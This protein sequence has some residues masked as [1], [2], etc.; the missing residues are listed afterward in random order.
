V[1]AVLAEERVEP[2]MVIEDLGDAVR[3][4]VDRVPL[5]EEVVRVPE[6]SDLP[7]AGSVAPVAEESGGHPPQRHRGRRAQVLV[8]VATWLLVITALTAIATGVP[9]ALDVFSGPRRER[10]SIAPPAERR[11]GPA[12]RRAGDGNGTSAEPTAEGRRNRCEVPT[13]PDAAER[14]GGGGKGKA[15]RAEGCPPDRGNSTGGKA[16]GGGRPDDPG[17][18]GNGGGPPGGSPGNE[19]GD[20]AAQA[21]G[22]AEGPGGK[23]SS[24]EEHGDAG[25]GGE[26]AER[27]RAG[28]GGSSNHSG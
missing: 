26:Q 24:N 2:S 22:D 12:E 6:A 3:R 13:S 25:V 17:N 5:R 11:A 9:N 23:G 8:A 10:P 7:A 15:V 28:A 21:G 27:G 18:R 20:G 16:G 19:G 14:S 4:A 1:S